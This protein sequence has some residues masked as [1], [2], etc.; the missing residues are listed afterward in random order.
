[1]LT[2]T[3]KIVLVNN[4]YS[5]LAVFVT[6][7]IFFDFPQYSRDDI[8]NQFNKIFYDHKIH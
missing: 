8:F 6:I 2:E 7:F 3:K 1:M 4:S 5:T